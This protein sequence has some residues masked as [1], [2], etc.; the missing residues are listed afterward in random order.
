MEKLKNLWKSFETKYPKASK[1][2]Y[3][4]GLFVLV[5]NLVTILRAL[6]MTFLTPAF[7]FLGTHSWGWPNAELSLFGV[8][9]TFNVIGSALFAAVLWIFKDP[10]ITL[11]TSVFPGEDQMSLQMRVSL[12]HVIFNVT[13]TLVL[14]PFVSSLVAYSCKVI[15]DKQ[16][17][18]TERALKYVD[19]RLLTMPSVALMQVKKELDYNIRFKKRID[20]AL[21][22]LDKQELKVI[23][24]RYFKNNSNEK[25]MELLKYKKSKFYQIKDRAVKKISISLY[26]VKAI[27][28]DIL[29]LVGDNDE[30]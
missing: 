22:N 15:K 30:S 1:W 25:C 6:M 17:E 28:Q 10:M 29:K 8:P 23:R 4:G 19:D 18:K 11:L 20:K 13:T 14:L 3:E 12:F 27:K 5:S 9:F 21:K 2:V 24:L 16:E 7:S 26:G